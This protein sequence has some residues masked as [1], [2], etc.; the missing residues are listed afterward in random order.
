MQGGNGGGVGKYIT[1]LPGIQPPNYL[2]VVIELTWTYP[3]RFVKL[4]YFGGWKPT[5]SAKEVGMCVEDPE[6]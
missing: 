3:C 2:G 6:K 4:M 1:G 5:E